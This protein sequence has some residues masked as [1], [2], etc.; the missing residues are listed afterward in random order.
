MVIVFVLV[1]QG[2]MHGLVT[3]PANRVA[4]HFLYSQTIR[5]TDV[6]LTVQL[7]LTIMRIV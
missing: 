4:P 6:F 5:P 7:V 2:H 1:P 3:T